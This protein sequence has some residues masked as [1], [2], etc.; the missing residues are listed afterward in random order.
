M[1]DGGLAAQLEVDELADLEVHGAAV[2]KLQALVAKAV[3]AADG[4]GGGQMRLEEVDG[5]EEVV[6]ARVG[7]QVSERSGH[8]EIRRGK[9]YS[10]W[11]GLRTTRSSLATL[12]LMCEL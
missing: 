5:G 11:E 10:T 7:A 3:R 4:V 6:G 8:P 1:R 9:A 12:M 2:M